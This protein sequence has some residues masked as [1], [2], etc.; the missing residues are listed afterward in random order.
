MLKSV[1]LVRHVRNRTYDE[2]SVVQQA[3]NRLSSIVERKGTQAIIPVL[4]RNNMNVLLLL[5]KDKLKNK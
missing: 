5:G 4:I 1:V 3:D 2:K